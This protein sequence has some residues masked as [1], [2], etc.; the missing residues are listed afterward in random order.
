M[1]L[2]FPKVDSDLDGVVPTGK[3]A[4]TSERTILVYGGST[5]T[6]LMTIQWAKLSGME[7][8]T[9]CSAANFGLV[10]ERG[11]DHVFDYHDAKHCI[12]NIRTVTSGQLR[13][14][15]DCVGSFGSPQICADAM[16]SDGKG[17]LYNSISLQTSPRE[18]VRSIFT[19]GQV[20]LGVDHQ[21]GGRI[22][23]ADE[24]LFEANKKFLRVAE[25]LFRL[26][27]IRPPPTEAVHGLENVL[28]V[29]D[30]LRKWKISGKK[31]VARI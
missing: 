30:D 19:P 2:P 10:R 23:P 8:V 6:G 15:L 29:I 25:S 26:G 7:I 11:A 24:E 3:V 5:T 16:A 4:Q 12:D 27:K 31:I 9:T 22:I 21:M 17:C 13:L 20:A 14:V 28:N 1:V 18:D